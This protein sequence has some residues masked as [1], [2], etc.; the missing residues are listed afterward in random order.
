[1]TP[2]LDYLGHI[3]PLTPSRHS[4]LFLLFPSNSLSSPPNYPTNVQ[5]SVRRSSSS[6]SRSSATLMRVHGATRQSSK[7]KSGEN[8][9]RRSCVVFPCRSIVVLNSPWYSRSSYRRCIPPL[10][11]QELPRCLLMRDTRTWFDFREA[12]YAERMEGWREAEVVDSMP[13]PKFCWCPGK[14]RDE[15]AGGTFR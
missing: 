3:R 5:L 11:D 15:K 6:R 14:S 13:W 12:F 9:R 4:P 8:D 2:S 10:D 1:M 7:E